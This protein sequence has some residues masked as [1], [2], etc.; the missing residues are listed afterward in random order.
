MKQLIDFENADLFPNPLNDSSI[1]GLTPRML[2]I[3][4]RYYRTGSV[5]SLRKTSETAF[6]AQVKGQRNKM[7]YQAE[8]SAGPDG[9]HSVCDCPTPD[10]PCKHSLAALIAFHDLQHYGRFQRS[11][12]HPVFF[13]IGLFR[14]LK[15]R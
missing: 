8:L 7:I 14:R 6:S 3:A 11:A 10:Q 5:K 15:L 13:L 1:S 12:W 9:F 2:K 4:C